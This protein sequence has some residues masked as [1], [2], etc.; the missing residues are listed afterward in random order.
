[1]SCLHFLD[2]KHPGATPPPRLDSSHLVCRKQGRM[3]IGNFANVSNHVVKV[4]PTTKQ[5][6]YT[7]HNMLQTTAYYTC[8]T[9]LQIYYLLHFSSTAYFTF[10]TILQTY[11]LLYFSYY[12]TDLLPTMLFILSY[13]PTTY[14][15]F[16][17]ILQLSL[18][19]I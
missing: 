11:Y 14:Y 15:T 12:P 16:H 13:R 7:F 18:I 19:H 8:H 10:H 6:Y 2:S 17:T 4:K 1:M 9:I 3:Y 5:A